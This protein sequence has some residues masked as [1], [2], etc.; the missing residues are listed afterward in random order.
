MMITVLW[1]EPI[2]GSVTSLSWIYTHCRTGKAEQ[3][4]RGQATRAKLGVPALSSK[5]DME[6]EIRPPCSTSNLP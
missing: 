4:T 2:K 5:L 1:T 6:P 3:A